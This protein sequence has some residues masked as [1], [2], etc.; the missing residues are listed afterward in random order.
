MKYPSLFF[1]ISLVTL[2]SCFETK[3]KSL[4]I[5]HWTGI[6]WLS[7]GAPS[8]YTPSKASFTFMDDGNYTFDYAGSIEKGE[9][10]ISNDQL[11]T[12]PEGGIKMMV[13]IIELKPDTLIF[14]M[15]RGGAGERLTLVK[16]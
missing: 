6:E 11:F 3:D 9:Y 2:T 14:D 1:A 16:N 5:G 12:T 8:P 13:K 15:N 7:E 4:I 10:F